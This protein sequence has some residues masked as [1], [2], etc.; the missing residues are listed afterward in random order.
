MFEE[1]SKVFEVVYSLAKMRNRDFGGKKR[2]AQT[3]GIINLA[4]ITRDDLYEDFYY[5]VSKELENFLMALD[6]ET[7]KI[8][9]VIMYLGRDKDYDEKLPVEEI[10]KQVRAGFDGSWAEKYIEVNQMVEKFPLD[11][12]L[13]NGFKILKII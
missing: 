6:F 9:Q 7:V 8:I 1:Y 2:K 10:Y 3:D 4:E 12:Y 11:K 13:A 5:G